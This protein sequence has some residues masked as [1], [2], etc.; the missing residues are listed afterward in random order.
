MEGDNNNQNNGA[1]PAEPQPPGQ[2][3]TKQTV[4]ATKS[5]AGVYIFAAAV[6]VAALALVWVLFYPSAKHVIAYGVSIG[7]VPVQGLSQ[8]E[9]KALLSGMKELAPPKHL[10]IKAGARTFNVAL[11]ELEYSQDFEASARAAAQYGN[12]RGLL[13]NI[14]ARLFSVV[15]HKNIPIITKYDNDRLNLLSRTIESKIEKKPVDAAIDWEKPSVTPHS[16]GLGFDSH[17]AVNKL[18]AALSL[19]KGETVKLDIITI[20]A[21]ITEKQFAGID[22]KHPLSSFS[23][24]YSEGMKN[25]S[26]NLKKIA[27][28][29]TGHEIK[30]GE[31]FSYNAVIGERTKEAGFFLAPEIVRGRMVAGYGGG[32]CQGSTTLFNAA[33]FAGMEDFQWSPHSQQ[34]HYAKPGRDAAVYYGQID[35][36]FRN[37]FKESV[38]V[39]ATGINGVLTVSMYSRFKPKYK[40][41]LSSKWWGRFFPGET[42]IEKPNLPPGAKIVVSKGAFG[43]HASLYR[44][45]VYPGGRKVQTLMKRGKSG[46]LRYPGAKRI[47]EAGPAVDDSDKPDE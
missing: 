7:G 1:P 8:D 30:P 22:F 23:T 17:K 43:L 3:V 9:A 6:A 20:P 5:A 26:K 42:I 45:Y 14:G 12:N 41:E 19:Y 35:L 38:Y 39:K 37:P 44:T 15:F 25:R 4:S 36:K 2:I 33:L 29:L 10:A 47:V 32:A 28:I 40:I 18:R 46:E 27:E 21:K 13:G 11:S 34:S 16:D 24:N 31:V